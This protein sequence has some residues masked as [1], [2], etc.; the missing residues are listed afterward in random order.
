VGA[1]AAAAAFSALAVAAAARLGSRPSV[2]KRTHGA[3]V[4]QAAFD[5]PETAPDLLPRARFSFA[6]ASAP[7][8]A[9]SA[10]RQISVKR[11]LLM[12]KQIVWRKPHKPSVKP[13]HHSNKWKFRGYETEGTK[14]HF[15]KYALQA[16]EEA[17]MSSKQ[18][19]ECRRIITRTFER[20]GKVFIRVVPDHAI[21]RRVAESRMGAGKGN[22]SYWVAVVRPQKILFECDGV[23]EEVVVEAFRKTCYILGFKA[24]MLKKE[25]GPS[26]YQLQ[27]SGGAKEKRDFKEFEAD[28][29]LKNYR[30]RM[31]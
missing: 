17:W 5:A 20:K 31:T 25:D 3:V 13:F 16:L 9:R 14:P 2:G 7:V 28:T 8:P 26:E 6:G 4:R 15:G 22:I 19:E 1:V 27:V 11:H 29:F 30:Q 21:T 18:I 10:G 12:P 23:S 24:R